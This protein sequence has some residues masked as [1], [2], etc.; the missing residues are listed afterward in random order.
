M[1]LKFTS[2]IAGLLCAWGT[3]SA[4]EVPYSVNWV[5]EDGTTASLCDW[6]AL[7]CGK[8][9]DTGGTCQPVSKNG[10]WKAWPQKDE[11]G[12]VEYGYL[13]QEVMTSTKTYYSSV[14][15]V[16]FTLEPGKNYQIEFDYAHVGSSSVYGDDYKGDIEVRL[17][18][19]N[20]FAN[21]LAGDDALCEYPVIWEKT[22]VSALPAL[23]WEHQKGSFSVSEAGEY[24]IV[25][26]AL[27]I[28]NQSV[29]HHLRAF[30]I[31]EK[32]DNITLGGFV[33]P[34]DNQES[35]SDAEPVTVT[36]VNE[37]ST[38]ITGAQIELSLNGS[39]VCIDDLPEI[40]A[41]SNYDYT[42]SKTV[43]LKGPKA[44]NTLKAEVAW[45][46]DKNLKDNTITA[47]FA[48]QYVTPTYEQSIYK[49]D[50]ASIWTKLDNNGDEATFGI[51][52]VYGNDRITYKPGAENATTDELLLSPAV[53]LKAG[54]LYVVQTTAW[55]AWP[56]SG[57]SD[58]GVEGADAARNY[59]VAWGY[60][61]K[62]E[63][64]SYTLVEDFLTKNYTGVRA[65]TVGVR[66]YFTPSSAGKYYIGLHLT[67]NEP[68]S[69]GFSMDDFKIAETA[70]NDIAIESV[71]VPG[72]RYTCITTIPVSMYVNNNGR[73]PISTFKVRAY[74]QS[75]PESA[76]EETV[77]FETALQPG[78][79]QT[80]R[81]SQLV[82]FDFAANDAIVVEAVLEG[83]GNESNSKKVI[84]VTKESPVEL[85]V[86]F[87]I[88]TKTGDYGWLCIDGD[89]DGSTF[90]DYSYPQYGDPGELQV[91]QTKDGVADQAVSLSFHLDADK[92]Y[93]LTC[94]IKAGNNSEQ[95]LSGNTYI[96]SATGKK[97]LVSPIIAPAG[98][99]TKKNTELI[100]YVKV[101]EAGE[102]VFIA[103]D[104]PYT[105]NYTGYS[106]PLF[107]IVDVMTVTEAEGTA[108]I[109][110]ISISGPEGDKVYDEPVDLTV[111]YK[112]AGSNEIKN[113]VLALTVNDAVYHKIVSLAPEATGEAKFEG[114]DLVNTGSYAIKAEVVVCGD[115]TPENN[116]IEQTIN[117]LG[118][119]DV[120]VVSLD[121]PRS[122]ELGREET[123]TV[124]VKNNGKG[125]LTSIPMTYTFKK[126]DE[127]AATATQTFTTEVAEGESAQLTFDAV[128]D[129]ADAATYSVVVAANVEGET[130]PETATLTTS[131]ICTH[132]DL[133]AGVTAIVGPTN[134]RFTTTENLVVSVKNY[135]VTMLYDVPV[136]ATIVNDLG[137]TTATV[138]GT[139]SE[140][141]AGATV[142]F[143]FPTAIDLTHG[144]DFEVTAAT[145]IEKDVDTTNDSCVGS[146]HGNIYDCGV[147]EIISP[148]TILDEEGN[149]TVESG[150]RTV[151]VVLKNFG[152]FTLTEIPVRYK[153]GAMPQAQ[154]WTGT[155]EPGETVEFSFTN[156]YNFKEGKSYTLTAYTELASDERSANDSKSIDIK[157]VNGLESVY[158]DAMSITVVD[159]GIRVATPVAA[160]VVITDAAGRIV[161]NATVEPGV[162][163]ISL[164]HGI[165]V[166][167]LRADNRA[168]SVKCI[169]K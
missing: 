24:Y 32:P 119:V 126:G 148:A 162:S 135:G 147:Y 40:P 31:A 65:S 76:Y 161:G 15:S 51:E 102:Y 137:E 48:P 108:D 72:T 47:S 79:S 146:I 6:T 155:L 18:T 66:G 26:R 38:P 7:N 12:N 144:G 168:S 122:G 164:A 68:R 10:M 3:A 127:V 145:T 140:I 120:E 71:S 149:A 104:A 89:L 111:A 59:D 106:P 103:E 53:D 74:S 17:T 45:D 156:T 110:L 84:E 83:D 141:A 16:P 154:N 50:Y 2:I 82:T 101:S 98:S 34:I 160:V 37:C 1:K 88:G 44:Y 86:E 167:T 28:K 114:I 143:I 96:A 169:V 132:E 124:T 139:I 93:K 116:V 166:V 5:S 90:R 70:E 14:A 75:N 138:N 159:R 8:Y 56:V 125:A 25:F 133:D 123:V 43:N 130:N 67:A 134:T 157:G 87:K 20:E 13:R 57:D 35:Y 4:V 19:T 118:I 131:I 49:N 62:N 121:T 78:S 73:N 94:G 29:R 22:G 69:Y 23:E 112:N 92:L 150:D 128:A 85:P 113:A 81:C 11:D 109:E 42:F 52:N 100:S 97:I 153:V 41:G 21:G 117:S 33:A 64:G 105:G 27:H 115:N 9:A 30:S 107:G 77:N 129:L 152:D 63:D 54:Q 151:T 58:Y 60:Y 163:E 46:G 91:T 136:T 158:G 55:T 36:V 99:S 142:D 95:L 80:V 39:S 165:Y 61:T